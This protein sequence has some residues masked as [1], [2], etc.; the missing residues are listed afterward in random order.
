ME[1]GDQKQVEGV[2]RSVRMRHAK[3]RLDAA[4]GAGTISEAEAADLID[5]VARGKHA[6]ALRRR[7]NTLTRH[8][9][10]RS[11]PGE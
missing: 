9:K 2:M 3:A 7:I 5:Q 8:G 1:S 11:E 4:V 10:A 6:K